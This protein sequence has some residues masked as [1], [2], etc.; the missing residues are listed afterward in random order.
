MYS[1]LFITVASSAALLLVSWLVYSSTLKTEATYSFETSVDFHRTTPCSIPEGTSRARNTLF[2]PVRG[3]ERVRQFFFPKDASYALIICGEPHPNER[4]VC[5]SNIT[6]AIQLNN[7]IYNAGTSIWRQLVVFT[8]VC[9]E[10]GVVA[11]QTQFKPQYSPNSSDESY[12]F[13]SLVYTN[14]NLC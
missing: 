6:R 12:T 11:W 8:A 9:E 1:Y 7:C 13:F 5:H 14:V 3:R 10:S 2:L 4:S